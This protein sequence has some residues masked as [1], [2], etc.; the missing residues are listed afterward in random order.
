MY[1]QLLQCWCPETLANMCITLEHYS[2]TPMFPLPLFFLFP[3]F[4]TQFLLFLRRPFELFLSSPFSLR[5]S[6]LRRGVDIPVEIA[7]QPRRCRP[8]AAAK[9]AFEV[10]H[11][12][13]LPT[14]SRQTS[15]ADVPPF[16]IKITSTVMGILLALT[17][18][19]LQVPGAKR[20]TLHSG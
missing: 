3:H 14:W 4:L 20:A 11:L 9:R 2:E 1:C 8:P 18:T 13:W 12:A 7:V 6:C 5:D 16:Q 15:A 10:A 19:S 17:S